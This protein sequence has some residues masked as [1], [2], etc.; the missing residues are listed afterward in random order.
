[1]LVLLVGPGEAKRR[2]LHIL[3][4]E[5]KGVR[6]RVVEGVDSSGE[7]GVRVALHSREVRRELRDVKLAR[8]YEA[9]EEAMR[10]VARGDGR[11]AFSF[12]EVFEAA[13]L[14]AVETLLLS[15]RVFED[16]RVGEDELVELLR[17]VE[18]YG[19]KAYLLDSSTEVG[20]RVEGLG[21]A[22]AL[23]RFSLGMGRR[24][25]APP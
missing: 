12:R 25:S 1:M 2:L 21:G 7:D 22:L 13:G 9:L 10:R 23:L 5:L 8:A 20:E 4:E 14:G 19:G 17:L 11:V 16:P 6:V 18:G 24:S 3:E 15:E